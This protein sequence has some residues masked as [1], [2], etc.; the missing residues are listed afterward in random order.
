M[1]VKLAVPS[2]NQEQRWLVKWMSLHPVIAEYFCKNNNEGKRTL[3][4]GWNLKLMGL[5]PGVSDLFIYY[6]FGKFSGLWLEIKRNKAYTKSE[7][8]TDTWIAQVKFQED[9]KRVGY[10]AFFA[11]GWLDAKDI[12]ERYLDVKS[13]IHNPR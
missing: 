4:Q 5:R 1:A 12:I 9:V 11:Y 7:R 10:S 3:A 2:E 13:D 6:P 8:E